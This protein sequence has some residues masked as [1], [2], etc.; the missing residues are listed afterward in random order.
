[1]KTTY[2]FF[3]SLV[4]SLFRYNCFMTWVGVGHNHFKVGEGW[5]LYENRW[6]SRNV[7]WGW[8]LA[9]GSTL[10]KL[11]I[12]IWKQPNIYMPSSSNANITKLKS[13]QR[14]NLFKWDLS[15]KFSQPPFTLFHFNVFI[16]RLR[17]ARSHNKLND[18]FYQV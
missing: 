14:S 17:N 10:N 5:H 18:K 1:M 11:Y 16:F 3:P 15:T 13:N 2:C 6:D 8:L 7:C 9:V 4:S 12:C